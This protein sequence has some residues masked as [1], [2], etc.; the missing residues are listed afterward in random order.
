MLVFAQ[1]GLL[2][3][4]LQTTI[5][6]AGTMTIMAVLSGIKVQMYEDLKQ[7]GLDVVNVQLVPN[8]ENLF[9]GPLVTEDTQWMQEQ[10][11]G[12]LLAPF[13]AD[14]A[15]GANLENQ[16]TLEFLILETTHEW[17]NIV[18]LNISE[19]RFI[20]KGET[21]FCVLDE[22]IADRFFPE[23]NAVGKELFINASE[24]I[25]NLTVAGVLKD[26][27]EVRKKFDELDFAGSARSTLNRMLEFKSIYI[28]GDFSEPHEPIH[29]AV[30]KVPKDID[31]L[32]TAKSIQKE[33]KR[34]DLPAIA[35]A[36]SQWVDNVMR[37]ADLTTQVAGMLWIVVLLVTSVMILT[38]SL[39]AIR[40]RYYELAVRR[41]EGARRLQIV[42]QLLLENMILSLTGG[43]L[44]IGL[45]HGAGYLLETRYLSWS[46]AF[47]PHEMALAIGLGAGLGALATILPA[48][49]AASLDPVKILRIA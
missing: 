20:Y 31:A 40:E 22:W 32:S 38:I 24:G 15:V 44:A 1:R 2:R 46:P 45:A 47:L 26:P 5:A 4:P 3:R 34:R 10:S 17:G 35:W 42:S 16:Q 7:V 39:V 14:M 18:P 36:R 27:F 49:R 6:L 37:G 30:I 13:R 8:L 28:L 33:A 48:Y 11:K 23:G 21:E 25:R 9:I 43:F 29:G 41:T 19:G 12:G